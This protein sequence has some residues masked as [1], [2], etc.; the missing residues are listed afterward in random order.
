MVL[1]QALFQAVAGQKSEIA[2]IIS[3]L[4]IA[5]LFNPLR[6]RIQKDIDWRF[7]HSQ[8]DAQKAWEGF[9]A[10]MREEVVLEQMTVQLLDIVAD[11]MKPEHVSLWVR[12]SRR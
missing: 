10:R 3:I 4:G 8:Y 11:T 9:A 6:M 2:I 12:P 5:T 7:Y 1:L